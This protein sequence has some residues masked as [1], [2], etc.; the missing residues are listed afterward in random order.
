M[1]E[2]SRV[3][4]WLWAFVLCLV[5]VW[6]ALL[7]DSMSLFG[8]AVL[9]AYAIYDVYQYPKTRAK[10]SANRFFSLLVIGFLMSLSWLDF[11]TA[12]TGLVFL[13]GVFGLPIDGLIEK[14]LPVK[15]L[16]SLLLGQMWPKTTRLCF[17]WCGQYVLLLSSRTMCLQGH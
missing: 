7:P 13:Q 11:A 17:F 3:E 10:V 6:S 4:L 15:M 1:T 14:R 5:C 16:I 8:V 12:L 2:L 9:I